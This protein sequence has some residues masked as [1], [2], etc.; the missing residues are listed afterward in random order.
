MTKLEDA[1]E[2]RSIDG[3]GVLKM[4]GNKNRG[5]LLLAGNFLSC[6]QLDGFRTCRKRKKICGRTLSLCYVHATVQQLN[7][8]KTLNLKHFIKMQKN[9]QWNIRDPM[10]YSLISFTATGNFVRL[11]L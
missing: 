11:S 6:K 7:P 9:I 5:L 2:I 3:T 10:L 4:A 8:L 1:N